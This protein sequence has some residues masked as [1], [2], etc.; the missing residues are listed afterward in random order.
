MSNRWAW[1]RAFLVPSVST[2]HIFTIREKRSNVRFIP[3]KLHRHVGH[4]QAR[5][6]RSA[7]PDQPA[8][9][10]PDG[11]RDDP[12]VRLGGYC[13]DGLLEHR[14]DETDSQG[15]CRTCCPPDAA[16]FDAPA[17]GKRPAAGLRKGVGLQGRPLRDDAGTKR[18]ATRYTLHPSTLEIVK[19]PP[20]TWR[21]FPI[22]GLLNM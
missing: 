16:R 15:L 7:D 3:G 4:R 9:A 22:L 20:E 2:L 12:R 13:A 17:Q 11:A 8:A 10:K 5:L 18:V 19:T 1:R 6:L 14:A 21:G